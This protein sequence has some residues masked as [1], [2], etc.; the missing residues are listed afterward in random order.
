MDLKTG[1]PA[2]RITAPEAAFAADLMDLTHRLGV[3]SDKP[4]VQAQTSVHP[5]AIART[6]NFTLIAGQLKQSE[7]PEPPAITWGSRAIPP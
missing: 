3:N 4:R 1:E 6:G 2:S 7:N 5:Q